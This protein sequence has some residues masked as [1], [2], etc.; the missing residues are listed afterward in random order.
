MIKVGGVYHLLDVM[1]KKMK[2]S[3]DG[4]S[5]GIP[6]RVRIPGNA[7]FS[8]SG[9]VGDLHTIFVHFSLGY[10]IH[11][12]GKSHSI[13]YYGGGGAASSLRNGGMRLKGLSKSTILSPDVPV[14]EN[15]SDL[16][17][18]RTKSDII[19]LV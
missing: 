8:H 3:D 17:S 18:W 14:T 16:L 4:D 2:A 7:K 5:P 15:P 12:D 9:K 6:L 13:V 10:L 11:F 19:E 1:F